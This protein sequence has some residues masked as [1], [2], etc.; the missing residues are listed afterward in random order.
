MWERLSS[1][2]SIFPF[3]VCLAA[4]QLAAKV[5]PVSVGTKDAPESTEL[6]ERLSAAK[7]IHRGC[8]VN[9]FTE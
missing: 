7:K 5:C 3:A 8:I 4:V 2:D 9:A 1:R 6:W